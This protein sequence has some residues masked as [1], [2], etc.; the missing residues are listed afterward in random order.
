MNEYQ[1]AIQTLER[2]RKELIHDIAESGAQGGVGRSQQY[3]AVLVTIQNAMN[4]INELG[5]L[6]NPQELE[7]PNPVVSDQLSPA[8]RMALVRA[9]KNKQQ[10]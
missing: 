8:D 1:K 2:S 7:A 3:A 5:N 6:T 4:I 10:Q 9:A